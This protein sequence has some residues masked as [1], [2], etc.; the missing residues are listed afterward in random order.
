MSHL[1][2]PWAVL[3][4]LFS[5]PLW[6]LLPSPGTSW[7]SWLSLKQDC[8]KCHR[9]EVSVWNKIALVRSWKF[10]QNS[11]YRRH[12]SFW[13]VFFSDKKGCFISQREMPKAGSWN[14]QWTLNVYSIDFVLAMVWPLDSETTSKNSLKTGYET[15]G[16]GIENFFS[17]NYTKCHLLPLGLVS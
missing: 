7:P 3:F 14:H 8:L 2:G 15:E 10:F 1:L 13:Y 5:E 11:S 9:Y 17:N 6:L 4:F 16:R 12:V